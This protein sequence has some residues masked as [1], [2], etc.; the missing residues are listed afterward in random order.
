MDKEELDSYIQAGKIAAKAL[1]YGASLI[2]EGALLLDV[3]EAVE[4]KIISLGGNF[5]FPPQISLNDVA[6][7]YC[8][9]YDDDTQFKH[10][11][12]AKLDVGVHINGFV[13]DTA[14]TV[15]LSD[16]ANLK[17]LAEAS[18]AALAA[19]LKIVRP[20]IR[21]SE[22]GA[23]IE[24]EIKSR[25]FNPVINLSGHGLGKFIIHDSPSI[26]NFN[27]PINVVLHEDQ[28][29]AI[30]P[31]AST[32]A[33]MIYESSNATIYALEKIQPVRSP[34]TREVLKTIENYNSLPFTQRWL[35]KKHG[36][37]KTMFAI[38]ELRTL[39]ILKEYPPLPDKGHGMV[40]QA[41]HTVI[42][43]DKPIVTT[44]AEEE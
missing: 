10:G 2:Q 5:A 19:A 42:V 32:G 17:L 35:V 31:F 34:M 14:R 9:P 27:A 12:I 36:L 23:A 30:E 1:D 38:K 39:G 33:G 7:H 43:R 25:G 41:E 40:S 11:D 37:G 13:A 3:T 44:R 8:S 24:R 16:D 21:V 4:E 28:V 26:P 18:R 22:I 6:A 29:I 15:V 20:G